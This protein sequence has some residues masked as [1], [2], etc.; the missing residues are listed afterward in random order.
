[1]GREDHTVEAVREVVLKAA[2]PVVIDGDGLFALAWNASGTADVLRRRQ[3]STILTPHDGEFGILTGNRPGP[4]RLAAA[5][6]LSADTGAVVLLKGPTT[7]VAGP[8]GDARV[9]TA[10]D[11]RLATAGTGDVLSGVVGALAATGMPPLHAA[12]AAAWIHGA[13]AERGPRIGL[14][15]RDLLDALPATLAELEATP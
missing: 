11:A 6:R 14:V 8:D 13:A 2:A 1:M 4:D 12:A 3:A 9:V 10:G 5:R 15:A 7:V